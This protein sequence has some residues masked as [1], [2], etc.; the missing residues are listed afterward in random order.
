MLD[1]IFVFHQCP[2]FM[3]LKYRIL[4]I[5][6][7]IDKL[8]VSAKNLRMRNQIP[9]RNFIIDRFF[10]RTPKFFHQDCFDCTI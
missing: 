1:D 6:E 7:L 10:C 2:I 4:I 5:I 3:F 8:Y 9:K